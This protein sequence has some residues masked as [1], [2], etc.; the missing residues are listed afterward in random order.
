MLLLYIRQI[1]E[2]SHQ[3][4]MQLMG[5]RFRADSFLRMHHE[6]L[7]LQFAHLNTEAPTRR[8]GNLTNQTNLLSIEHTQQPYLLKDNHADSSWLTTFLNP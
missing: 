3:D 7:A 5:L 2:L 1:K 4:N 8:I 6:S